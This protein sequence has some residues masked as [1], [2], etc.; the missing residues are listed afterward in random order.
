MT[1]FWASPLYRLYS[2][3]DCHET[4]HT[5][6]QTSYLLRV[7]VSIFCCQKLGQHWIW[8]IFLFLIWLSRNFTHVFTNTITC[9]SSRFNLLWSKTRSNWIW[10]IFISYPIVTK[11]HTRVHK[12]LLYEFAF[13]PSAV[14]NY[15]TVTINRIWQNVWRHHST[16]FI[17]YP[18]VT[19]RESICIVCV[20]LYWTLEFV[21]TPLWSYIANIR[22]TSTLYCECSY[23]ILI[24][25][26][27][28][29]PICQLLPVCSKHQFSY[30]CSKSSRVTASVFTSP[31]WKEYSFVISL[32]HIKRQ[33]NPL[34]PKWRRKCLSRLSPVCPSDVGNVSGEKFILNAP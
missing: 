13:W 6:S 10:Q 16:D 17:S 29:L 24:F 15:I 7:H 23:V 27:C 34:P 33:L 3:S 8:Q 1:D 2:L 28:Q 26:H 12:H 14:K 20:A 18:I 31:W 19:K 21:I 25:K 9:T 5:C 4:S 30:S 22:M 32:Q 11:L